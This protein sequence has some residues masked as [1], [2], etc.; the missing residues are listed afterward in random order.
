MSIVGLKIRSTIVTLVYRK[1]LHSSSVKLNQEFTM[2][3]IVNFMSTDSD[4]I[5]NSCPSFHT[6]WSI[7]LQLAVTLYL[8]HTQIGISFLAGISFTIILIPINKFIAN[9]IG[10]LST[11]MMK[12]KDQRVRLVGETLR[13]MTTIKLNVWEEH[14]LRSILRG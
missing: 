13:G 12:F 10:D 5:V 2:G 1:I 8:L 14:F 7:P 6:L 9:K 4:R 3:E 11:K